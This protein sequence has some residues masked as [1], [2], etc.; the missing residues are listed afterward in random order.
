MLVR[1]RGDLLFATTAGIWV[2]HKPIH[3]VAKTCTG[4]YLFGFRDGPAADAEWRAPTSMVEAPCGAIVV[5]DFG[6]FRLRMISSDLTTV[7][8]VVGTDYAGCRDGVGAKAV[9]GDRQGA[10]VVNA[11]EQLIFVDYYS[12]FGDAEH[13]PRV[14]A[15]LRVVDLH[16]RAV[17]TICEIPCTKA[18]HAVAI[19]TNGVLLLAGDNGIWGVTT[20]LVTPCP[21][22]TLASATAWYNATWAHP[23]A[24]EVARML[25]DDLG[26]LPVDVWGI[27]FSNL[28]VREVG[29]PRW[30]VVS[31]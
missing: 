20:P 4:T 24:R 27:V 16:T 1:S 29:G 11:D 25:V 30:A 13:P 21:S 22:H 15:H 18:I 9:L 23:H 12:V 14:Q 7:S 10:M 19:D 17:A 28:R 26:K 6:S 31:N 5:A 3:G 8:T 2:Y